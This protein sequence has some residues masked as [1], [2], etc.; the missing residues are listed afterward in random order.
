MRLTV[1]LF[2]P[3]FFHTETRKSTHKGV[4]SSEPAPAPGKSNP[5]SIDY[6]EEKKPS[7]KRKGSRAE[8]KE[9]PRGGSSKKPRLDGTVSE[10]D[11]SSEED[12]GAGHE[13]EEIP[14]DSKKSLSSDFIAF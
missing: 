6:V 1:D 4:L 14:D 12:E 5:L 13:A 2:F 9:D 11:G 10:E 3:L 7:Q 8:M